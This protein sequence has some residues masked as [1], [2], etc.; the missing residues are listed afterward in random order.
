MF[1]VLF[2]DDEDEKEKNKIAKIANSSLDSLLFGLGFGGAL[3]STVKNILMKV[4]TQAEKNSP[5]YQDVIWDVFDV[6]PV[7][8]SKIRK[9]R[10]AA[11][12]FEWQMDEIKNRG[13]SIDNPAYLAIA[14]MISATTN[15][16]M[17]R[18]LRKYMNMRQAM[19][20][21]TRVWQKVAL[22]LGWSGWALGLPYWGAPS[23]IKQEKEQH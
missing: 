2:D 18:V 8:D 15:V 19:D 4:A 6:S 14:Q 16:P 20:E 21:E 7:L 10:T 13:W 1:A 23:T 9:L 5:Q 3:I 17:D 11:R 22:F 12:T